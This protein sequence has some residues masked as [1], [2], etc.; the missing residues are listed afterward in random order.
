MFWG[1]VF[2]R[3]HKRY[4]GVVVDVQ[5]EIDFRRM[6]TLQQMHGLMDDEGQ[7]CDPRMCVVDGPP[8]VVQRALFD[9]LKTLPERTHEQPLIFRP[10]EMR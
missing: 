8:R 4:V 5:I 2:Q 3:A 10:G 6:H 1:T 7:L 9:S